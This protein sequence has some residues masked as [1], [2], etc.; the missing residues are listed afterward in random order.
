MKN[1]EALSKEQANEISNDIFEQL[2]EQM[3]MIPNVYATI[4]NSGPALK[5]T[6]ALTKILEE[7]EFSGKEIHAVALAVSQ[8]NG[9]EYCLA[10]HTA[11]AKQLGF[12]E[13]ETIE[14]RNG[15][16]EDKKL[17]ALTDLAKAITET[18]GYPD[19]HLIDQFFDA[20][21]SKAALAELIALVGLKTITNYTNHIAETEIDFPKAPALEKAEA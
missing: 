8:S 15:E 18:R 2:E 7:G 17:K 5:A 12:S 4:G 20:G 11:V 6:M 10:A 13:E 16:I 3:D 9:C 1:L 21:Y 14:I 19:Q